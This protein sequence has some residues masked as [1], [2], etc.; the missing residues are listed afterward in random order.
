MNVG[1]MRSVT[2]VKDFRTGNNLKTTQTKNL[3]LFSSVCSRGVSHNAT[4][5]LLLNTSLTTF[6]AHGVKQLNATG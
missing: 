4:R 1:V 3:R 2:T 6:T 5:V